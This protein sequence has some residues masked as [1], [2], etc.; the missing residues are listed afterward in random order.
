MSA[1]LRVLIPCLLAF[2]FLGAVLARLDWLRAIGVDLAT[3]DKGPNATSLVVSGSPTECKAVETRCAAKDTVVARIM[4][5]ELD[6]FEAAACF[7]YLNHEPPEY[8]SMGYLQ[9]PGGSDEEK[10]CRQVIRWVKT[11]GN[12]SPSAR[13]VEQMRARLEAELAARLRRDGR[14]ALPERN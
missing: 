12:A 10:L 6:L 7:R 8:R 9:L 14:I 5:G 3:L 4:A 13:E 11:G 1:A 2:A